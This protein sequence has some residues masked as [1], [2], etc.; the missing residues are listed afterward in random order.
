MI[1]NVPFLILDFGL[2][3]VDGVRGLHLQGDGFAR[4]ALRTMSTWNAWKENNLRLYK[5]L[6]IHGRFG[7]SNDINGGVFDKSTSRDEQG[8]FAGF[9]NLKICHLC[10]ARASAK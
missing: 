3:I 6:H 4:K 7:L 8:S 5:N 9:I 1:E 2:D 10:M